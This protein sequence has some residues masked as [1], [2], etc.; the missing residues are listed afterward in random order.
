MLLDVAAKMTDVVVDPACRTPRN[1]GSAARIKYWV[2][3]G[4]AT[5][6][7]VATTATYG[8]G[9]GGGDGDGKFPP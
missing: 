4:G 9:T 6:N 8:A 5:L 7:G 2:P 1:N 3:A